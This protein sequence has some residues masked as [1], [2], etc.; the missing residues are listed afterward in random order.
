MSFQTTLGDQPAVD[1]AVRNR[2][3]RA[4]TLH[5]QDP[6]A[7]EPLPACPEGDYRPDAEFTEVRIAVYRSHYDLCQNPECFGR[8][9]R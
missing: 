9:W 2:S 4:Y 6:D 7:E 5:R 3:Y 8:D 1:R